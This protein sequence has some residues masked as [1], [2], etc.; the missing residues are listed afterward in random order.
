MTT[1]SKAI[2]KL[3]R[4]PAAHNWV[5]N[6]RLRRDDT[7]FALHNFAMNPPRSSLASAMAIC[8]QIVI[9]GISLREALICAGAIKDPANRERARWIIQAFHPYAVSQGWKG[10]EVFR[11]MV[12]YYPVSAGVRVPV[13]PTFVL[14]DNGVLTPYF[15]I[16]WAKMDLRPYQRQI[17]S[18]L[19]T[20]SILSLEEFAGSNAY[21]VCTPVAPYSKKERHVMMWSVRDHDVL[22]DD[23]KQLLFDRYAGAMDDAEKMLIESLS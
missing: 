14:N 15:V 17:L 5:K 22:D 7:A 1:I 9:D 4:P 10:I 16:C 8:A 12:E 3:R 18:T 13:K 19:I 21:I 20:E 6:I 11:G 2:E 23:E